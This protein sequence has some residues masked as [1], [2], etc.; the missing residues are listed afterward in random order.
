MPKNRARDDRRSV[1]SHEKMMGALGRAAGWSSGEG[2]A[3]KNGSTASGSL[4]SPGH[5]H[6]DTG[7]IEYYGR[8]TLASPRETFGSLDATKGIKKHSTKKHKDED[9]E[10]VEH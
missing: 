5:G 8:D 2:L 3:W 7:R 6:V 10:V 4:F 1:G 9:P